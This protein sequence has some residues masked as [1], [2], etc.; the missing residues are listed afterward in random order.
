MFDLLGEVIHAIL[1]HTQLLPLLLPGFEAGQSLP[2]ALLRFVGAI[3]QYHTPLV[4]GPRLGL[5]EFF[6]A[7]L[8]VGVV[9]AGDECGWGKYRRL[10]L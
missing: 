7:G 2:F 9:E 8:W 4:L 6:D 10:V 1:Q 3:V 5:M